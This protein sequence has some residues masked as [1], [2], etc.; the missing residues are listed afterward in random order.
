M[1]VANTKCHIIKFKFHLMLQTPKLN[2]MST[3]HY[4]SLNYIIIVSIYSY[5]A[6]NKAK[7]WLLFY[8]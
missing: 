1:H 4:M 5:L 2:F 7:I 6:T 3:P 8:N